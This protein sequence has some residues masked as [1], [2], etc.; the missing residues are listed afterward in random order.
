MG[1]P[2]RFELRQAI[3]LNP[4]LAPL[5]LAGLCAPFIADKLKVARALSFA[6]VA[7]TLLNLLLRG[8]SYYLYPVYP[9][10]FAVGAVACAELKR[11]VT[12]AWMTGSTAL[13]VVAAPLVLPIL[14]PPALH[15]YLE[16]THLRPAPYETAAIG[17]PLIHVFSDELGW[18]DLAKDVVAVYQSLPE[19]ERRHAAIVASNYGEAAAIDV[20]AA[21]QNL[22][23]ALSGQNQYF[24]WGPRNQEGQIII[25]VNGDVERWRRLCGTIEI[26]GTFGG[27]YVMPYENNRPIFICR[28]PRR[29][30]AEIWPRLKR[31][32]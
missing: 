13:F 19:N 15:R 1:T 22:P 14:D 16:R 4:L 11:W 10:M 24:L 3:A 26:A 18:R 6:F 30:L 25:H 5:W 32:Q 27:S 8:K 2:L 23:T 31:Y 29:T 28:Q 20:Y 21:K 12:A 9:T 7:T 17:A